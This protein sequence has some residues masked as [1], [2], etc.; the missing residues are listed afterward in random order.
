M[1]LWQALAALAATPSVVVVVRAIA[2]R[3]SSS[4][5]ARTDEIDHLRAQNA[6]LEN[7]RDTERQ[8]AENA[9]QALRDK[10]NAVEIAFARQRGSL[11]RM[12]DERD[13]ALRGCNITNCPKDK[14]P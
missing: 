6:M 3:F 12:R 2:A 9:K 4:W 8:D 13:S 11:E 10:L 7:A 5:K 14:K 1:T